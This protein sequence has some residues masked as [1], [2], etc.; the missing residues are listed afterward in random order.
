MARSLLYRGVEVT[1]VL[2]PAGNIQ[3]VVAAK[4][5]FLLLTLAA[6]SAM[7][8]A[9]R[10]RRTRRRRYSWHALPE[11]PDTPR[12]RPLASRLARNRRIRAERSA[13]PPLL[14]PAPVR[15]SGGRRGPLTA[16][17]EPWFVLLATLGLAV[18]LVYLGMLAAIELQLSPFQLAALVFLGVFAAM[19]VKQFKARVFLVA[20]PSAAGFAILLFMPPLLV[21]SILLAGAVLLFVGLFAWNLARSRPQSWWRLRRKQLRSKGQGHKPVAARIL[22]KPD[23]NYRRTGGRDGYGLARQARARQVYFSDV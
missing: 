18:F 1:M 16:L 11:K 22:G 7:F 2:C 21:G 9:T 10:E 6:I 23:P 8:L 14:S 20:L 12:R 3:F 5:L 19:L 15:Q 17:V 13:A 4:L